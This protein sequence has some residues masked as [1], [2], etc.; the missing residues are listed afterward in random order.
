MI[1]KKLIYELLYYFGVILF[2]I[3][4]LFLKLTAPLCIGILLL[5]SGMNGIFWNK[6][7]SEI[8]SG[9]MKKYFVWNIFFLGISSVLFFS[10]TKVFFNVFIRGEVLNWNSYILLLSLIGIIYFEIL[11][12]ISLQIK[13]R[14][15]A[16]VILF[17]FILSTG[18]FIFGG[19]WL[20]TDFFLGFLSLTVTV[21]ISFRKTYFE[22]SDI[23]GK[24]RDNNEH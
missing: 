3:T 19:H 15:A 21:I 24:N 2:L 1:K 16:L 6:S 17:L 14:Y 13:S 23:L 10:L 4:G 11:F 7:S 20:K 12:R 5:Y 22:L 8:T 9:Y 18:A